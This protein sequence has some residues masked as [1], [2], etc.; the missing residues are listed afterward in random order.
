MSINANE[1]LF[2]SITRLNETGYKVCYD[3]PPHIVSDGL[4]GGQENGRT[5][6]KSFLPV[7]ELQLLIIF[8][9][10]QI[11]SFLLKPL[12][13][14]LFIP[15]MMVII[16]NLSNKPIMKQRKYFLLVILT[17]S[18]PFCCRLG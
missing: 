3:A 8:I 16:F 14:P 12:R 17:Q 2:N 5:P 1:T 15:Q 10:T 13:L 11:C 6:M 4:W 18:I 9:I 7:I